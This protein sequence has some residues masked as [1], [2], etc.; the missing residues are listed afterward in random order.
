MNVEH[1]IAILARLGFELSPD[2]RV[3][4]FGCGA[5]R[6]VYDLLDHGFSNACGYDVKD[7]LELRDPADRARFLITDSGQLPFADRS[8][9]LIISDQVLEHVQDQ[10]GMLRELHRVMRPG[11]VALH[12]FPARYCLLENHI[13]VPFGGVFGH[14]WWYKLWAWLGIRND[15]QKGL[16][17][18]ETADRNTCYFVGGLNYVSNSC[19]QVVWQSLGYQWKWF[20]QEFLD[21]CERPRARLL[22][23][24]VRRLPLVCWLNRTFITR[25]VFLKKA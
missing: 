22:G 20:D 17:A 18:D 24:I 5:G 8:F 11:G 9:D 7:Y 12:I 13:G 6:C 1:R 2:C 23:R 4:D 19:Y 3:L 16:S 14:R 21:T 10:V 25:R 15:F